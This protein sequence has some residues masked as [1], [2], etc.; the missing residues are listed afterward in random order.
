MQIG[1]VVP[2]ECKNSTGLESTIYI[3]LLQLN[4]TE[5]MPETYV[6][7]VGW[8]EIQGD[9]DARAIARIHFPETNEVG[10]LFD[11]AT[12]Q[13]FLS[14]LLEA[15]AN[16]R[17][18]T[19]AAGKLL[20][21]PDKALTSEQDLSQLEPHVFKKEHSN[22]SAGYGDRF[23]L[24]LLRKVEEGINPELE[25][26]RFLTDRKLIQHFAP[27]AGSLE[28]QASGKPVMTIGILQKLIPDS[29]D[30]WS[31]T[32]DTLRDYFEQVMAVEGAFRI[33]VFYTLIRILPLGLQS[34]NQKGFSPHNN[35]A[36]HHRHDRLSMV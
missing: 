1:E 17:S 2:V 36:Y 32:L 11:A 14:V 10:V 28:Y 33:S 7:P 23:V 13:G 34:Y 4:Y 16:S 29:R 31:Y 3:L 25:I 8:E 5:G 6:L 12:D 27:I 9:A 21:I 19:G 15:I 35:E 20:G 22:T 24:K 18:Y 26:G 30:S